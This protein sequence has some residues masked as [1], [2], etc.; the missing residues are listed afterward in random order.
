MSIMLL[1]FVVVTILLFI[2]C[3]FNSPCATAWTFR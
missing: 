2:S 1:A 3:W